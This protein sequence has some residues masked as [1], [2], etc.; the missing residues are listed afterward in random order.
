MLC[1]CLREHKANQM[2]QRDLKWGQITIQMCRTVLRHPLL[3]TKDTHFVPAR[4]SLGTKLPQNVPTSTS[5]HPIRH[6][7]R[8]KRAHHQHLGHKKHPQRARQSAST[9][10]NQQPTTV[11]RQII[12]YSQ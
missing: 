2:C 4:L 6:K 3:G 11:N 12:K 9:T 10:G 8:L 1:A 5:Q 7:T